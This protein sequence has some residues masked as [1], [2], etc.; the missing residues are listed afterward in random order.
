MFSWNFAMISTLLITTI[1]IDYIYIGRRYI[2]IACFMNKIIGKR[3]IHVTTCVGWL[4]FQLFVKGRVLNL[5]KN[6]LDYFKIIHWSFISHNHRQGSVLITN[7]TNKRGWIQWNNK[8]FYTFLHHH[9]LFCAFFVNKIGKQWKSSEA[10][11]WKLISNLN[12]FIP[13]SLWI[14]IINTRRAPKYIYQNAY[15]NK[16]LKTTPN[17]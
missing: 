7:M 8:Y 1:E 9:N 15:D 2:G 17:W 6:N 16:I 13:N 11:D 3:I 14:K 12:A 4:V 10:F 5:W